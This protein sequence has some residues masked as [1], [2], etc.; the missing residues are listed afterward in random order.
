MVVLVVCCSMV[1]YS[2]K[3]GVDVRSMHKHVMGKVLKVF[4][5][6]WSKTCLIIICFY[7]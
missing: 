1:V 7:D 3:G 5:I 6:M 2:V 4:G